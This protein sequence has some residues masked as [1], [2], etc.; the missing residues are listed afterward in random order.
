M[1]AGSYFVWQR[2]EFSRLYKYNDNGDY[3]AAIRVS[4]RLVKFGYKK[5]WAKELRAIALAEVDPERAI[6]EMTALLESGTL[7]APSTLRLRLAELQL[8][9]KQVDAVKNHLDKLSQL[10]GTNPRFL[11]VQAKL[12]LTEGKQAEAF[13]VLRK[14][15]RIEPNHAEGNLIYAALLLNAKDPINEVLAKVSLRKAGGTQAEAGL[16]ALFLLAT[17]PGLPLFPNDREWLARRLR[18]HPL[19]NASAR[20]LA[21]TQDLVLNSDQSEEIVQRTLN[22]EGANAPDMMAKWLL[23]IGESDKAIEFVTTGAGATLPLGMSAQVRLQALLMQNDFEGVKK[24]LLEEG[25]E[26]PEAQ[27]DTLLALADTVLEPVAQSSPTEQWLNAYNLGRE[28]NNVDSVYLLARIATRN[29]WLNEAQE[30]YEWT[31]EKVA[32]P[33]MS[34]RILSELI[35]IFSVRKEA[36]AMLQTARRMAQVKPDDPVSLN[37]IYY[38]ETLLG[39]GAEAGPERFKALVERFPGGI[40]ASGYAFAL[41]KAGKLERASEAFEKLDARYLEVPACRLVGALI[42]SAK[43]D[44]SRADQLLAGINPQNLLPEELLLYE[45]ISAPLNQ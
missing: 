33:Q 9:A 23:Q 15:L 28:Q 40:Y 26:F 18:E 39:E 25:L 42:A 8:E 44:R 7:T 37:N 14:L 35:V 27:R 34:Y 21:S 17:R 43:Q 11:L 3:E 4:D 12:Y 19:A 5:N 6:G 41:F 32:S 22:T 45:S 38:L 2:L 16:Q 31:L 30:A 10:E 36:A 24:L 13:E 29:R 20:I 1:L